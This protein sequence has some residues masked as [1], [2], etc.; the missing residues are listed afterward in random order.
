[1]K[2]GGLKNFAKRE[3]AGRSWVQIRL[4]NHPNPHTSYEHQWIS[5]NFPK[6]IPA[7]R[8][9]CI[10]LLCTLWTGQPINFSS[11]FA[12]YRSWTP[13]TSMEN[14]STRLTSDH[15]NAFKKLMWTIFSNFERL[16]MN[17]MWKMCA[18]WFYCK[19][20]KYKHM[21]KWGLGLP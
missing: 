5:C 11:I 13:S 21:K 4:Q 12:N 6:W 7:Y 15:L 20:I 10:G 2:A 8:L 18:Y 1:M 16:K 19:L 17:R 9:G 3:S 14:R